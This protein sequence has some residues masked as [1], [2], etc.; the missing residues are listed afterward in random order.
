MTND[1]AQQPGSKADARRGFKLIAK[2]IAVLDTI[3]IVVLTAVQYL[4][5][6]A[7]ITSFMSDGSQTTGKIGWFF[8]SLGGAI[9]T[10]IALNFIAG[11]A[12]LMGMSLWAF[13][14]KRKETM[15]TSKNT[16][17]NESNKS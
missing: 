3:L 13:F 4:L 10:T 9:C 1:G 2:T 12:I 14:S 11:I 16:D 7:A 6:D 15:T 17:P 8:A 5:G